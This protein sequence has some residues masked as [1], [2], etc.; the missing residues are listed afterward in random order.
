LANGDFG[1]EFA[2][3]YRQVLFSATANMQKKPLA[4]AIQPFGRRIPRDKDWVAEGSQFELS[5]DLA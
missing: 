5:V 2:F 4:R 1:R 3:T